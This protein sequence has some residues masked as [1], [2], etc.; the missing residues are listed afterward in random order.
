MILPLQIDSVAL[1]VIHTLQENGFDAYLVGGAVRD[2][3]INRTPK[4]FDVATNATNSQIAGLFENC[5]LI[6]RR[7][8]IALVTIEKETIEV[9]TF[10]SNDTDQTM[11]T[12]NLRKR[13]EDRNPGTIEE[14]SS[15]RDFTINALYYNPA[16]HEIIDLE[17]GLHDL[18]KRLLRFIGN[19]EDKI[20]EDPIRILRAIKQSHQ[21][22]L[23]VSKEDEELFVKYFVK[24]D[25]SSKWRLAEEVNKIFNSGYSAL[26]F[27]KLI[28]MGVFSK[29]FP[30]LFQFLK[31]EIELKGEFD[32]IAVLELL[33]KIAKEFGKLR[34]SSLFAALAIPF[35]LRR[36]GDIWP[37]ETVNHEI[38]VGI[39]EKFKQIWLE[40]FVKKW[41]KIKVINMYL[42]QWRFVFSKEK[43]IKS[44][45]V[46][47]E[48]FI[49]SFRLFR[50]YSQLTKQYQEYVEFW[51]IVRRHTEHFD[52][53]L[54]SFQNN[55][56][57]QEL[58]L[59]S[60]SIKRNKQKK[61][62]RTNLR[63]RRTN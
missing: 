21:L 15:R 23:L 48:Y 2:L 63:K 13:G 33:D 25:A 45:F 37:N 4:D 11:R 1:Q 39:T 57:L 9:S 20:I 35:S 32:L 12:M 5:E 34:E 62:R 41:V 24:I 31:E 53:I 29:A 54:K 61:K 60:N 27:K 19:S 40:L 56:K 8:P 38:E 16:N 30:H 17:G 14:D 50:F 51:E 52:L 10:V 44:S 43:K 49:D 58:Q 6:G 7:F 36:F 55:V 47:K 59:L 3:L 46:F 18:D 42:T 26:I 28:P 22:G